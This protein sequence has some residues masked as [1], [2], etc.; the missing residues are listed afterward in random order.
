MSYSVAIVGAGIIGDNH[1]K[2]ILRHPDLRVGAIV[3]VDAEAAKRLAE[4]VGAATGVTPDVFGT[5]AEALGGVHIAV[6]CSPSG[7]H[8]DLAEEALA[9]G[10]HLVIE[11]PLDS[12]LE[13]AR[14]IAAAADASDRTVSVICQHRFD[15]ASVTVADAVHGGAFG[16][17]TSAVASVAW[18]R[19][20]PYYDSAGWRGTWAQDG[21]GATMNQGVHTV[22]LLVWLL[23]QP[24]E[25]Y[26]QTGVLAH[27][28]IEVE[29]VAVATVRFASGALAVLHA[30]TAAYP[31]L[32]VRL[33]VYGS[34]GSAVIDDDRLVYF[35][36]APVTPGPADPEAFVLGHLR[37]W[38]DIVGAIRDGRPAGVTVADALLDL[39]VVK[40]VYVSAHLGRPVRVDAV[41]LG[42]HDTDLT[43]LEQGAR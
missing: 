36:D 3:D 10:V 20:Q 17:I 16:R 1:A 11:K 32:S 33:A 26:A 2:A 38:D 35:Q 4:S 34:A 43:T 22:D 42:E 12:S 5:L 28:R 18:W 40:A 13:A 7:T 39:A 37:Q 14:R 23:G 29:D 15:P 19:G 27:E 41:L 30:T 6:I 24:V 21:G 8:A 31:G 9:A 25:V